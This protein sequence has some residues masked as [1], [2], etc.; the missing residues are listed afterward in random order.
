MNRYDI[1]QNLPTDKTEIDE[2]EMEVVNLLFENEED[3]NS[4]GRIMNEAYEPLIL[5]S[6]FMIF[7]LSYMNNILVTVIPCINGSEIFTLVLKTVLFML[8]FW[9]LKNIRLLNKNYD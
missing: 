7:N 5:G 1:L 2:N 6:L 4:L 3:K 8:L 9:F